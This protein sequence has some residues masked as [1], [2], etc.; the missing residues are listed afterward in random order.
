VDCKVSDLKV[1]ER[2]TVTTTFL[3]LGSTVAWFALVLSIR[4]WYGKKGADCYYSEY[5]PNSGP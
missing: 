5:N 3:K 4:C 1:T 2:T